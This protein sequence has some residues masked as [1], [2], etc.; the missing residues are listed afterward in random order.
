MQERTVDVAIIGSGSAGLNALSQTRKAGKSFVLINGGEPGTTCAR[1][2]CMPSKAMIQIAEDY[3]RRTHLGKFGVDGHQAM[4]LD[5]GEALE[6]V[7]DLRDTF[8]DRVLSTSTDELPEEQFIQDFA[9]LV[10][11]TLVEAGGQRIR[12]GAVVIATGSRPVVPSAWRPFGERILTTDELF[13]LEDLPASMAVIGLGTI[14]LELGQSLCRLGVDVTGFDQQR[15][16]AGISDP[17]VNQAAIELIGKE[18]PLHLGAAA[19]IHE[20]G[21]RLRVSAGGHSVLVDRV[22]CSIGRTPNIDGLGLEVLSDALG[23][24]LDARGLPPFDRHSMQVGDLP[25]FIAGDVNGERQILH[26]A[27]DEGKIAGWNAARGERRRFRRKTPLF[28]NFC[29]PNI[30]A[31]GQR[32]DEIDPQTAA[33]GQIRFAPVGR[34]LIMGKNRGVLRVYADRASGRLLGA[35]M[36]GPKGEN[37]A[38]LLC[39]CIEQGLSVGELLRMPFYHP[40]IEEA[41]QAALYDLYGKLEAKNAG[42]TELWPL[43]DTDD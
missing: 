38:H 7:Q 14:G 12:A 16:I 40:V 3:H 30:C 23:V 33:V 19:E 6:H 29:D 27:G 43:Q 15:Q 9:R 10:E 21:D 31:V 37:L 42:L 36:I 35:E 5:V 22:L 26:E 34:A 39:W 41:L 17:E 20:D 13:E 11:P 24:P 25:V 4:T 8:V 32:F 18:M 28:I 1:V 2:G